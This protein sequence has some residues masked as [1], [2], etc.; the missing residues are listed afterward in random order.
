MKKMIS[1]IKACMTQDMQIFKISRKNMPSVRNKLLPIILAVL[2]GFSMWTYANMIIEPLVD[3]H[4][5][6]V[7]LTL[8]IFFTTILTLIEGIYKSS[9]LLFYCRDDNLMLSLPI[10]KSTV[11]FV[12]IF[13]FYVFE[14]VYN[15][16]FLVPAM[17][18]YI[19]YVN[20]GTSFYVVSLIAIILLPVIP[21]LISCIIGG[22]ISAS[23]SEFKRKSI[24]QIVVSML[25]LL[26]IFYLSFNIQNLIKDLA[27]NA[28]SINDIITRL[29]YPAGA[30]I[31]LITN[32]KLKDLIVFIII[33][34]VAFIITVTGMSKLYF[35]INSK[36]KVVK[37][38]KSNSSY[39][40]K[41]N[42]P[43]KTLIKKELNK[44]TTTPVFIINAGFGLVLYV[45][46]CILI[47]L[48][49]ESVVASLAEQ[50]ISISAEQIKS[51]IPLVLF[52][53]ITSASFLSAITCSMISLEG[54]T[55]NLLKSLP[56][57]PFTIIFSKVLTAVLIMV[58]FM[59]IGDIIVFLKFKFNI[60]EIIIL[61]AASIVL[62]L[63]SETFGIIV[64]LKYPKM[65]A[66]N[67]TEVVKQSMSSFVAVFSGIA[68]LSLTVVGMVECVKNN[69]KTDL[70]IAGGLFI[71]TVMCII[72]LGFLKKK[73]EKEFNSINV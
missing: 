25:F 48:K 20:V 29:Y 12:R 43:I 62:P 64:N 16:L 59:I 26:F 37:K 13:K 8:F 55:F 73:G 1:L 53:L 5:E 23:S 15:S 32:Y 67:D 69:I 34:L 14:L 33:H 21:V 22:I 57:R 19:R 44:F 11:L 42:K 63:A 54:K 28:T 52:G 40:I 3:L 65:D 4:L 72:L 17:I 39:K 18:A 41:A 68:I 35:K 24:A 70:I 51:F 38:G 27:Q 61:L 71:F 30:Y 9:S 2:L 50:E 31:K 49:L 7:M 46:A 58:P 10:K 56:V 66:Q 47:C 45:V 60:L 6:Y 36:V